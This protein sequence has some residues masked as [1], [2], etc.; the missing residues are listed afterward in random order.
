MNSRRLA[1]FILILLPIAALEA[2]GTRASDKPAAEAKPV[3]I[4]GFIFNVSNILLDVEE[5]RG[6]VGVRFLYP[7]YALRASL[8]GGYSS[9]NDS[10]EIAA[11]GTFEKP[12]YVGRV[13][14]L[15]GINTVLG[16]EQ[17]RSAVDADNWSITRSVS[18]SMGGVLGLEF[19]ITDYVSLMV[20][21]ELAASLA[22]TGFTR[23]VDGVAAPAATS[24][25]YDVSTRLGNGG[26][27]SLVLY[28]K[29]AGGMP[30][31]EQKKK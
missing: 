16:Y 30:A 10:L 18:A 25:N 14:P 15:W 19:H 5:Y 9:A 3:P 23:A 29:P 17:E 6:G 7:A 24:V 28:L 11:S 26:G 20:E 31:I 12:F 21:Y 13:T 4:P 22:W 8:G 27:I 2:Q 1:I